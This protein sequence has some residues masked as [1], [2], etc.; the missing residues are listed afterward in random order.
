MT[1]KE[2]KEKLKILQNVGAGVLIKR[3]DKE[4]YHVH[5]HDMKNDM[6]WKLMICIIDNTVIYSTIT[7]PYLDKNRNGFDKVFNFIN[8]IEKNVIDN[9]LD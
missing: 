3:C 2:L 4:L 5:I 7:Y 9:L 1:K 8:P 6:E